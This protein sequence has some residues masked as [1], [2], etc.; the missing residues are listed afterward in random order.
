MA[1]NRH[2]DGHVSLTYEDIGGVEAVMWASLELSNLLACPSKS[3]H[4]ISGSV[5]F[6]HE[7]VAESGAAGCPMRDLCRSK[8]GS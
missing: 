2:R 5:I 3:N 7:L 8:S 6:Q 4:L 1:R